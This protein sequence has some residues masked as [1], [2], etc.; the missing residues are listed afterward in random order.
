MLLVFE[1][2]KFFAHFSLNPCAALFSTEIKFIALVHELFVR[3]SL[4]EMSIKSSKNNT[5]IPQSTNDIYCSIIYFIFCCV[6]KAFHYLLLTLFL[7]FVVI[8]SDLY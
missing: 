5:T 7:F 4:T 8:V 2:Q 3:I 1:M 6:F